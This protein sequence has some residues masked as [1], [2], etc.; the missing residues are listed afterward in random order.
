[1]RDIKGG[2]DVT[3]EDIKTNNQPLFDE[4]EQILS[5]YEIHKEAAN[6]HE[7]LYRFLCKLKDNEILW[8]CVTR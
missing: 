8:Q 5:Y 7:D 2:F 6:K 4:L 3:Y 1:M